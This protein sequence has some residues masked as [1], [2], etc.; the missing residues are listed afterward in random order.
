MSHAEPS[1]FVFDDF[2]TLR[3]QLM[4]IKQFGFPGTYALKYDAVMDERYQ[5]LLKEYLD[6]NDEI[7]A[8][9]EISEPLC[10]RAGVDFHKAEVRI[11]YDD[12]VNSAYSLGYE[13]WERKKLVDAY[14]EDFYQ[15]FGTYP[16][17]IGAWV[18]DSVTVD[19]AVEHYGVVGA[20]I[21]RDQMDTDGFTLWGGIPN[22]FYYPSKKNAFHSRIY[23]NSCCKK[24]N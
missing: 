20:A 2:D 9:W 22:G 5:A 15:V 10:I 17:T 4:L 8:W 19:Y 14:M 18:L 23:K 12:R 3:K 13:P 7:S 21:C 16:K 6:E 11:E 1:R 24:I